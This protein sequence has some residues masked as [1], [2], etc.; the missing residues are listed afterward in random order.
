MK[1]IIIFASGSGSNAERIATFFKDDKN[2]QVSL[3]LSNNPKAG[4]LERAKRLQIPSI[5]F[6]RQ[7]FYHSEIVLDIIQSQNP[8]L[9][10]LAGF[11]WKFP[12]NIIKNFPNKIINIHPSLLP[13]YG[14][15]GMYGGFVHQSVIENRE[16]ESG[17]TI[18]YVNEN[19][20]EGTIIF[21][22]KTEVSANDTPET[23]AEKIHQLEY[24][25]F[26]KIIASLL[27]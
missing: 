19:Y 26:P 10:I 6:D 18:H 3:I 21:Q 17:I 22:T 25:H 11:L 14:G 7:A 12:E 15:K 2:I 13:K 20:D 24:E 4:V 27:K 8:D 9:I 16:P 23:L 1:K 5:V